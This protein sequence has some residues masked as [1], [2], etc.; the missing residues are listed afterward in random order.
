MDDGKNKSIFCGTYRNLNSFAHFEVAAV[1]L[2]FTQNHF[3]QRTL[4]NEESNKTT[5]KKS[6]GQPFPR[7]WDLNNES[8]R[9]CN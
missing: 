1:W 4:R 9:H 8:S 3:N 5:E 7:H 2:H 6:K